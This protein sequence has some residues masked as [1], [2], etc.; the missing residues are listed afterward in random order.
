MTDNRA[1]SRTA[2]WIMEE[3]DIRYTLA[4]RLLR[5]AQEF[6]PRA[7]RAELRNHC[8]ELLQQERNPL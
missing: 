5:T 8:K 2:R 4:L 1:E 6:Y 7:T 3:L